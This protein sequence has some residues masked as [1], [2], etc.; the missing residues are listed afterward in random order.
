M[1]IILDSFA[2]YGDSILDVK[3]LRYLR[4][5]D[6][7]ETESFEHK[8]TLMEYSLNEFKLIIHAKDDIPMFLGP[9]S[10]RIYLSK[11]IPETQGFAKQYNFLFKVKQRYLEKG[12]KNIYEPDKRRCYFKDETKQA[13]I[14]KVYTQNNCIFEC[15][16]KWIITFCKCLPWFV[17]YLEVP[18]CGIFGNKCYEQ[19]L[20]QLND[21]LDFTDPDNPPCGCFI[22]CE[23]TQ[24]TPILDKNGGSNKLQPEKN[25]QILDLHENFWGK[26]DVDWMDDGYVRELE[27]DK[28]LFPYIRD[29]FLGK[30]VIYKSYQT[31]Y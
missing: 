18:T 21:K 22:N 24:Y 1:T 15:K 25:K 14:T 28:F 30:L 20:M 23:E 16:L 9:Q 31:F 12:L 3:D 19:Q 10:K 27:K 2:Y 29:I 8:D 17:P 13:T 11:E 5:G 4:D 6:I 26:D 7:T